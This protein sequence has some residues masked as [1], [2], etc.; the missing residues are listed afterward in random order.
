MP[1]KKINALDVRVAVSTDLM[2]VGDPST[3]TAYK[4]TLSTLPLVPYTG[5]TG[6][7]NLGAYDLTVN[8]LTVGRGLGATINNTVVGSQAGAAFT[9]AQTNVAIGEQALKVHSTGNSNTAV[10]RY[11]MLSDVDGAF[12]T[13]LG[14]SALVFLATGVNTGNTAVGVNGLGR[15]TSGSY[16]TWLGYTSAPGGI[17]TSG[18]YNTILGAQINVGVATLS[19]NII[20]AD[21]EG[22][23]RFRDDA[24]STILSRLAGTGTRMVISDANGALS[25]QAITSGTVTSVGLTMPTAFGVANS[26]VTSSGTLAVTAL[27]SASQYIRGDG[28]LATLPTGGSGGSS[29]S[30][31]LN[32]GTAA[33]VGTYFQMSTNAV[34]GTNVDF[35]KTGNGLISQF[36][37][38]V[39]DPNRLQIPAGNWNFE[40]F[41]SMSS[42]GGTPE[43]YVELL[44]YDGTTFTSIAS[45]SATPEVISGGTIIDLYLTSLA[46]P[47]TTLLATDRLALRVYIVNNSGGRTATLHTQDSHL[48]QIITNFA[49]GVSALNGL[50]ANTQYFATGTSGTDFGI[51]SV[52]DTHTFNL[53]T[54]SGT[55]RGAL[56]S[57]DWTTFNSKQAALTLTTT[58]TS[59]AATLV[60]AT[61]NIPQYSGGGGG[62]MAIGGAITSATAGS[63]LFAGASGV[64]QQDN[65]NLFWD[66]T[67]ARLAIGRNSAAS[68]LDIQGNTASNVA[69]IGSE[70]TTTGSGT[71]WTGSGFATGYTHTTGSIVALTTTLA[72]IPLSYY[73]LSWTIT[74]RTTGTIVIVFGNYNSGSISATSNIQILNNGVAVLSITPTTDFNGTIAMSIKLITP[75]T[76]VINLRNSTGAVVN[77]F[78]ASSINTNLFTGI[79][80]G[81]LNTTGSANTAYGQNALSRNTTGYDNNAFGANALFGNTIGFENTAIGVA[82]L[83][84]NTSGYRNISVGVRSM[85]NNSNG[86]DNSALGVFALNRNINGGR[87]VAIG[88]YALSFNS[89]GEINTAIGFNAMYSMVGGSQNT[90]TGWQSMYLSN[91]HNNSA[92]GANSLSNNIT[93]NNNTAIGWE[94]L[95]ATNAS[96]NIALGHRAGKY[97]SGGSTGNGNPT[98]SLFL[99]Y[100]TKALAD[101]Q[102]NQIVIGYD[103]TGLGSNT[104]IIGNSSTITTALRGRL[105]LGTTTDSGL[106]QADI[107]G[108]TRINQLYLRALNT[109]P[110]TSTST[111]TLGEIRIDAGAI[112]VCT[113]TN[114]WVRALLTTF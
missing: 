84:N 55:N 1:N 5:A 46:I 44:K 93:G 56:S 110:A 52:S 15:L 42:S 53:P 48:C 36:L 27:G 21:G 98:N 41:F 47:A 17:L 49:G 26:P 14:T 85:Q 31:Y 57:A 107:N 34:V 74:G 62:S 50:T 103:E 73:Q 39:G 105:I 6:A 16:N 91:A 10:G 30:Y 100:N 87:N 64:L 95:Q 59:G 3:G 80:A 112:Y 24:T 99:G 7:V 66:D 2:L 63:V 70:L 76:S 45:S 65:A 43:F 104:T 37:T 18:S 28:E 13:A 25:T 35:T 12:N 8:S 51:S 29:V 54:A 109:A 60:G 81:Q 67:N 108:S 9:T 20:L 86:S 75:S 77:E 23:I 97:I 40:M 111:G 61:L 90:A 69:V 19:N 22:N 38:D 33:S 82:V 94:A 78:R 92:Y 4:S 89:N 88:G 83:G 79:N 114:T 71:N 113:A 68:K 32:G 101:S 58:G 102:T 106:Y 11:A 96:N 72:A